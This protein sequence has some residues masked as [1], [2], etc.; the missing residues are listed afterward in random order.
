MVNIWACD[1]DFVVRGGAM[2]QKHKLEIEVPARNME[3]LYVTSLQHVHIR[4]AET[5][6]QR[7]R[8]F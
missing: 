2:R 6:N 4:K 7:T 8:N 5:R 1:L 3:I